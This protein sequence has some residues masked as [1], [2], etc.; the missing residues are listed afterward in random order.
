[1]KFSVYFPTPSLK[2]Y[3]RQ[4]VVTVRELENEYKVFPSSGLVLGFQYKGELATISNSVESKLSSAGITGISD[5]YKVFKS[6]ANIG[7][8]LVYFTENRVCKL[9]ISSGKR[10]F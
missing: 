9:F 10:P 3:V 8:I 4:Y 7:T 1:M 2:P 6:S 5:R